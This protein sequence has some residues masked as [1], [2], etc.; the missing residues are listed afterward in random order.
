MSSS[1]AL[2]EAA[3]A[4]T[5]A[6]APVAAAA[7]A[8]AEAAD[9]RVGADVGDLQLQR[10]VDGR[11]RLGQLGDRLEQRLHRIGQ[12]VGLLARLAV[13]GRREDRVEVGLL[14]G[15]AQLAKEVEGLVDDVVGPRRR[16]VDLVI[17]R[18]EPRPSEFVL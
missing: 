8:D 12:R 10:L 1:S 17:S 7:A 14:V 13:D 15:G 11:H 16:L 6:A 9:E 18:T 4:A 2:A 5:V 3:A